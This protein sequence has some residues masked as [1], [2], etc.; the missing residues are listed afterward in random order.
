MPDQISTLLNQIGALLEPI[1]ATS[2]PI[3]IVLEFFLVATTLAATTRQT[4]Q[5]T[6]GWYKLQ[7]IILAVATA[8][9][10]WIRNNGA[11]TPLLVS[12]FVLPMVLMVV[13]E[14]LLAAAT[15]YSEPADL[16][17]SRTGFQ[18]RLSDATMD[19][20][21]VDLPGAR[22]R[23]RILLSASDLQRIHRIWTAASKP[24]QSARRD[25]FYFFALVGIAF[26]IAYSIISG[27]DS[28]A[29][30]KKIGLGVSLVLHLVGLY[31]TVTKGDIV[32]QIIGLLIMDHGLYLAVV[33]I[34]AIPVPASYFVTALYFYTLITLVILFLMIPQ[35]CGHAKTIDLD[36]IAKNSELTELQKAGSRPELSKGEA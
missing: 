36:I 17:G 22:T 19:S 1:R 35:V 15:M 10:A 4:I 24:A 20:E 33:K 2:E 14:N 18:T 25:L 30:D 12:I 31:N 34:V 23:Y 5:E 11:I 3:V 21:P 13:I 9:T 26:L 27:N 8:L 7:C 28:V 16:P 6:I 32:A 29:L